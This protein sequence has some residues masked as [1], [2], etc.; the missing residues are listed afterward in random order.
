VHRHQPEKIAAIEARWK[1]QQPASEVLLA[2]P[3]PAHER[4]RLAL[5]IPKL[6][7]ETLAACV[8]GMI[9][10]IDDRFDRRIPDRQTASQSIANY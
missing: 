9:R 2:L 8:S 6:G 4:N 5:E 1:T 7:R 3:D 10:P